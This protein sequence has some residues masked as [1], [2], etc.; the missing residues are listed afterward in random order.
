MKLNVRHVDVIL[1]G[2]ALSLTCTP[3]KTILQAREPQPLYEQSGL[4]NQFW[5][6]SNHTLSP[7]EYDNSFHMIDSSLSNLVTTADGS[8]LHESLWSQ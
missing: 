5:D 2:I 4:R 3:S 7:V 6:I 1:L 8:V